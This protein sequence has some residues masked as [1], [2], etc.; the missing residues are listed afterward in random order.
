M[1]ISIFRRLWPLSLLFLLLFIFYYFKISQF[2]NFSN[3]QLHHQQLISW[4][5]DHYLYSVV[6]FMS[7]YIFCVAALF[8]VALV[9][10]LAG[11]LLF[12][13]FWG[14]VYVVISATIGSVL[15]FFIVK[16][17]LS[18]WVAQRTTVWINKTRIGF[19][20]NAFSYLLILRLMPLFPFW[21]VNI[22]PALL[23]IEVKTFILAT[24]FGIIPL[25]IIYSSIGNSLNHILRT[26]QKLDSTIIFS[27]E[28]V[29][30]LSGLILLAFLP[31]VYKKI[32]G[33][34][35]NEKQLVV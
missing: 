6:M 28:I 15:V 11:G 25:S 33:H 22:V 18:D 21:V 19:K 2:I 3:L 32:K 7:T 17:A 30:P 24:F 12:G 13:P 29:L 34:Y 31:L 27:P 16:Y 5:Q 8:P 23:G 1:A 35:E 26:G 9:L 14:P 4:T 20:N 10:T